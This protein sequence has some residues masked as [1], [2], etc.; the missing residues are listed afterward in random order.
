MKTPL[1]TLTKVQSESGSDRR[2]EQSRREEGLSQIRDPRTVIRGESLSTVTKLKQLPNGHSIPIDIPQPRDGVAGNTAL[3]DWLN[4]TFPLAHTPEAL[5][6]FFDEFN[7]I[8]GDRFW[9]VEERAGGLHGW[10]RSFKF[11]NTSAMFAIGGQRGTAFLS[12]PGEACALFTQ[13]AWLDLTTI[14][15][16]IYKGKITRWDGA[17]DDFEGYHSVDWAVKQYLHGKFSTGGNKPCCCQHGN[18]IKP[19]GRGRTFEVGRRKNGKMIRIYEKGKQLGDSQ[20]PWVR[21]ELELHSKDREIPWAVLTN[22][23]GYVAGSYKVMD[24]LNQEAC[25]IKTQSN[26]KKISYD[27][28]I[29]YA[30]IAYGPLINVMVEQEGDYKVIIDRLRSDGV[31]NRLKLPVLPAEQPNKA[32]SGA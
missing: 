10:K 30:N 2:A 12:L 18:W 19:D 3:T 13:R 1:P 14:M 4:V 22:I 17:V 11:G 25:R 27:H 28:L 6:K 16:T 21:W 24:W 9:S 5:R 8:T 20:S 15:N 26:T 31:P 7:Q 23:G 29:K 32:S